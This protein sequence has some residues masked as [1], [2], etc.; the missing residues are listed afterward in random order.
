MSA[1]LVVAVAD[2]SADDGASFGIG[3]CVA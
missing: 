3:C 2:V 1:A